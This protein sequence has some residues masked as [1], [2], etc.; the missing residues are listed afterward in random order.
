MPCN[1]GG[2]VLERCFLMV[3][4]LIFLKK[5]L[6]ILNEISCSKLYFDCAKKL[7]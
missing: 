7:A 4:L 3:V 6:N 1:I 2:A 5:N